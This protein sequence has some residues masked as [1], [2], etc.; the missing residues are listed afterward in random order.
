MIVVTLHDCDNY[1]LLYLQLL[2]TGVHHKFNSVKR[3]TMLSRGLQIWHKA[4]LLLFALFHSGF[5]QNTTFITPNPDTPCPAEPCITLS[6][7]AMQPETSNTT[8]VFLPGEHILDRAVSIANLDSIT[9]LGD[10]SSFPDITSRITCTEPASLTFEGIHELR[11]HLL[12]FDSCGHTSPALSINSVLQA[13][14]SNCLF[15]S[16]VNTGPSED[17]GSEEAE[18]EYESYGQY[19]FYGNPFESSSQGGA[20][21]MKN[22]RV[23]LTGNT[24]NNNF[25]QEG[26]A[27]YATAG[28]LLA[29]NNTFYNN[30]A[31]DRGGAF[32][33]ESS[34]LTFTGNT[35]KENSVPGAQF[36][37]NG[38]GSLYVSSCVS[39][40]ITQNRFENNLAYDGYGGAVYKICTELFSPSPFIFS[41]NVL[42]NNSAFGGGALF[43]S[44]TD[45]IL[46]LSTFQNNS[47]LFFGGGLYLINDPSTPRGN[48]FTLKGSTFINNSAGV[49]GAISMQ[50]GTT[51]AT[52]NTFKRNS[53][54]NGGAL[55]VSS[56]DTAF[57]NNTFEDNSATWGGVV[58]VSFNATLTLLENFFRRNTAV[59]GGVAYVFESSRVELTDNSLTNNFAELGGTILATDCS[60]CVHENNTIENNT[61][62]FGGSI[63]AFNSHIKF[64][65]DSSI[66]NNSADYGG[67]IYAANSTL[68]GYATITGNV[69]LFGG[70]GVYASRCALNFA[71]TSIFAENSALDGAG[72]L[73]SGNSKLNLQPNTTISFIRNRAQQRGGAINVQESNP[74]DDCIDTGTSISD[75]FFQIE[76]E[77][78]YMASTVARISELENIT[79]SFESNSAGVAGA[80]LYGGSID[81]CSLSNIA[82]RSILCDQEDTC[83]PS[84]D[85]FDAITRYREQSRDISSDPLYLCSCKDDAIDCLSSFTPE[86]VYPGG[87]LQVPVIVLG[88]RNGP[89]TGV[90]QN[91]QPDADI[92]FFDPENTQNV[93]NR[94]TTLKYTI[95]SF[96]VET[97]QEMTLYAE[98][99]CP[100]ANSL[101]VSDSTIQTNTLRVNLQIFPCPLGFELSKSQ[102]TCI[103]AERLHQF[104]NTCIIDDGTVQRPLGAT[105]WFCYDTELEGLIL[106][107]HCPFDYCVSDELYITFDNR[108]EQCNFNRSGLLCGECAEGLSLALGSSNCIHCSNDYLA[109]LTVFALA[110]IA[111]VVFL[112]VLKL[113]VAFG[114]INGLI[115]YANIVGLNSGTFFPARTTNILTVFIAWLNLDLGIEVCF[116]DG[117]DTY[118]KTWLQFVFPLYVW[119]L[120]GAII[121]VCHFSP[122][123]ATLLGTNP[124]A[125]LSTLFLLSYAKILSLISNVLSYTYLEYPNLSRRAVWLY[126]GN[127]EYLT[128][129]HIPLFLA[130]LAFLL[131]LFLPFTLVLVFGQWLQSNS[132]RKFF[133]WINDYRI[134]P[135]IDAFHAPYTDKHRYWPGLMLLIRCALYLI[136]AFNVLGD[137]STNLLAITLMSLFLVIVASPLS[138]IYQKWWIGLLDLSFTLNLGILAAVTGIIS[139]GNQEAMTFTSI[140]IAFGAFI[141]IIIYHLSLHLQRTQMWKTIMPKLI[142][143]VQG[144]E[145]SKPDLDTE[146]GYPN[147]QPTSPTE[148][149]IDLNELREP[150]MEP[151]VERIHK[152]V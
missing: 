6:A 118:A 14:I 121:L 63:F 129:K 150:C 54:D 45:L 130:A 77:R 35:F 75:C 27:I 60:I 67:G 47:A 50:D 76:T 1:Y 134:K 89:T 131:V 101:V 78:V 110:G 36:F 15:Q 55:R 124:I 105:F 48:T 51:T 96:A 11:I 141:G 3:H 88:Q 18:Y 32:G 104:T 30:S 42:I 71:D 108:D 126:D 112:M 12:A 59:R 113:T 9:I 19:P 20:I 102:P 79:L 5:P 90:I 91:I 111:L 40:N 145:K 72:L 10:S 29:V 127:I 53:A 142:L 65:E 33:A 64:S 109:L 143:K 57:T 92:I 147:A 34:Q 132:R 44:F 21:Y 70:G 7:Y 133:S 116:Y 43:V 26:G 66:E 23:V 152:T 16:N 37:L 107:P 4:F 49:G 144:R 135:F 151:C 122:K 98:G 2:G 84:G 120:V 117:M 61:A 82:T 123:V 87:T 86:P 136:F 8:L 95:Q 138:Y 85:I 125:V 97:S 114:T 146:P 99:P 139:H 69:A 22:S 25:A 52:N 106:H 128:G 74:L 80:V 94:C 62:H 56:G 100:P 17:L 103:C 83:S 46:T 31:R 73:L 68:S 24:L 140:G 148:T 38:G 93:M 39:L 149:V 41:E 115:F 119:S 28:S 13:R 137:P 81:H 58:E